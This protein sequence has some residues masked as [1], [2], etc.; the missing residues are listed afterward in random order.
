MGKKLLVVALGVLACASVMAQSQGDWVLA[1][2]KSGTFW[3]PGVVQARNGDQITIAYDDGTRET[4]PAKLVKPY[5][6]A[7]GSRVECRWRGGGVWYRGKI[8]GVSKDRTM[9][10]VLYDDGDRESIATG[11]CRSR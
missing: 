9:I 2:W 7:N 11:F 5:D 6:W 4:L 3:F 1:R 10:D 8:T